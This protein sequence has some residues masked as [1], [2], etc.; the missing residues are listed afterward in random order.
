MFVVAAAAA[1][2]WGHKRSTEPTSGNIPVSERHCV[3]NKT[4]QKKRLEISGSCLV[5]FV[6]QA[7]RSDY[8]AGS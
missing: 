5:R 4:K 8:M 1:A 6:E 3:E 7:G 2:G